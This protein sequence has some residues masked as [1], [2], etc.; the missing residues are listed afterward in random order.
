MCRVSNGR[1]LECCH[2]LDELELGDMKGK[3]I[4]DAQSKLTEMEGYTVATQI[5]SMSELA[6]VLGDTV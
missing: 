6:A 1:L 5:G 2:D 3:M 4:K